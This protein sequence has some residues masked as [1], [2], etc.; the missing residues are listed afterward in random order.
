MARSELRAVLRRLSGFEVIDE[1]ETDRQL[2]ITGRVSEADAKRW[3]QLVKHLLVR[4]TQCS[5]SADIS[6]MYFTKP[7]EDGPKLLFSW[8]V[9]VRADDNVQPDKE[10]GLSV[11]DLVARSLE[12][13]VLELVPRPAPGPMQAETEVFL[14]ASPTRSA[15]PAAPGQQRGVSVTPGGASNRG[16]S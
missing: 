2:R 4:S 12:D 8:R 16:R 11:M 7:T 15:A 9:I 14:M 5:W 1:S 10:F 3:I 6:R 13:I